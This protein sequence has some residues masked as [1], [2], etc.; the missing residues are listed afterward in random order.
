MPYKL[1]NA[2][3][4]TESDDPTLYGTTVRLDDKGGEGECIALE[5]DGTTIFIDIDEWPLIVEAVD[6]LLAKAST[7]DNSPKP[8]TQREGVSKEFLD[9]IDV[10]VVCIQS[11]IKGRVEDLDDAFTWSRTPQGQHYWKAT[12]YGEKPLTKAD[13]ELLQSWVDAYYYYARRNND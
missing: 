7:D 10:N 11:V 5:S 4:R 2:G 9:K 12:C 13:K 8:C 3:F 6:K 1:I